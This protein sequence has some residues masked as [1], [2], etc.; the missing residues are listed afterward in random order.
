MDEK[1]DDAFIAAEAEWDTVQ[2]IVPKFAQD[3]GDPAAGD[4]GAEANEANFPREALLVTI[5]EVITDFRSQ[6][7]NLSNNDVSAGFDSFR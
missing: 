6:N 3:H 1:K 4:P 5:E 2:E 7:L